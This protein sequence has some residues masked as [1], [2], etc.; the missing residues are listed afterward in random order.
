MSPIAS[1]IIISSLATGTIITASS[2]HWLMAWVGLEINTLAIIPLISKKHH[3]RATEASTK[4]FLTQAAASA[5]I[6]FASTMN[7]QQT[8]TWDITQLTTTQSNTLLSMALAMKLG[9][10]PTHFWLPEVL[11][12]STMTTALVI[13]TW[14][15]L[16]PL[17]LLYMSANNLPP[18]LL[19]I[20]GALS[21]LVGGWG[22]LNQTQLRKIMAFSSIAHLGWIMTISFLLTNIMTLNLI[23]YIIMT[24]TMFST[25]ILSNLKTIKDTTTLSTTS[26]A[27]TTLMALALL[28]LGGLP[29]LSGFIPKWLILEELTNQ[30]LA[31]MAFLMVMAALLSLFFY[32]RLMYTTTMTLAPNTTTSPHKW[33][34]TQQKSTTLTSLTAPLTLLLLP[35][36][37]M[38]T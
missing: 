31:P 10:A 19:L 12:G 25:L 21:T 32:L 20:L 13:S 2:Y 23:I 28:S 15:K 6:L 36:T 16:A 26:P 14:Q 5:L 35:T 22:G 24:T 30:N 29:P 3:P 37:Q 34:F 1:S 4:Y 7:A 8:G 17:T 33:R 27:Q 18:T 9:L 11:Q 38:L